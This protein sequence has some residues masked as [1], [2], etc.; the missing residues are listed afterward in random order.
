MSEI[1]ISQA[2][3]HLNSE[4][5]QGRIHGVSGPGFRFLISRCSRTDA[6]IRDVRISMSLRY[7]SPSVT[8]SLSGKLSDCRT[9]PLLFKFM[10]IRVF[11][12]LKAGLAVGDPVTRTNKPLSVELGP[13]IMG[14]IFDGIQRPLKV[15]FE[16]YRK[17]Q[18]SLTAFI[19][20]RELL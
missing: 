7:R 12:I 8:N 15:K 18:R 6:G 14:S 1:G 13:G 2:H 10:K 4:K 5:E 19:W 16:K 11:W 3:S 17:L 20:K 9:I